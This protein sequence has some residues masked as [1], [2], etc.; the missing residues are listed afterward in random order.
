MS[1]RR[2]PR[3]AALF[4]LWLGACGAEIS[5]PPRG[6]VAVAPF[7][8]DRG[9]GAALPDV[10]TSLAVKLDGLGVGGVVA[11]R[12]VGDWPAEASTAERVALRDRIGAR[13]LVSGSAKRARG[14]ITLEARVMDLDSGVALGPP[15]V[16]RAADD[17]DLLRALD[18]LAGSVADRI[19]NPPPPQLAAA[20]KA[21]KPRPEERP[22]K[23]I[24]IEADTLDAQTVP[25]GRRLTFTGQVSAVQGDITLK[26][27]TLQAFYP[28]GA[29]EPDR[30]VAKGNIF[31]TQRDRTATCAEAIFYRE[32]EKLVC[33]GNPAE[34][35]EEC[36]RAEAEKFTFY[37]ESEKVE[38]LRPKVHGRECT[39]ASPQP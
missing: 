15:L 22:Q 37:L 10:A 23:P 19:L 9:E 28:N 4:A 35:T 39:P 14:G 30:L 21:R 31:V 25:G 36:S 27:D 16:E 33:T 2:G 34:L 8:A 7:V 32:E 38:M 26:C 13:T 29:S 18:A 1:R 11:P 12:R 20:T 3:A 6:D 5:P 17:A 24:E